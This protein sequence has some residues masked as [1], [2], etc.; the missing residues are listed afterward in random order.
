MRKA[1]ITGG[2][3]PLLKFSSAQDM[4]SSI[5]EGCSFEATWKELLGYGDTVSAFLIWSLGPDGR[6]L[7]FTPAF[8]P[9]PTLAPQV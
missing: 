8:P 2:I 6:D 7:E 3:N 1:G 4:T 5:E 9:D